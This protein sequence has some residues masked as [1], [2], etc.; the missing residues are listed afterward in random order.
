MKINL[1]F[2]KKQKNL[3]IYTGVKTQGTHIER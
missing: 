1:K 3:K 2:R